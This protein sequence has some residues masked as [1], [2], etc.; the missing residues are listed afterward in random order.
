MF[1]A[2]SSAYNKLQRTEAAAT[3]IIDFKPSFT[4]ALYQAQVN[5]TG[6]HLSG[7]LIVKAMPD[8]SLRMVFA[9][10]AGLTFFDFEFSKDDFKVHYI[11]SRLD[12]KPVIK[13]L[14]K[15]F[16]L[17]LMQHIDAAGAYTLKENGDYY[18]VFPDG[19]DLYY[20]ITD[21]AC[22]NLLRME[23]GSRKKRVVEA[24]MQPGNDGMPDSIGIQHHNFNFNI[25]LKRL[26]DDIEK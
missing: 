9:N 15:D 20:Y 22:T 23:R 4:R 5:V 19:R 18:R 8:S 1:S 24:V 11:F 12:K 21:S 14:R 13:T 6:R 2:C 10:E 7:L 3:C 16:E 25:G 17:V 26:Q